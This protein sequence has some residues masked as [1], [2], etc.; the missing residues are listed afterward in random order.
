MQACLLLHSPF[1]PFSGSLM[2]S[3]KLLSANIL[4]LTS[5]HPLLGFLSSRSVYFPSPS[6]LPPRGSSALQ[7][8]LHSSSPLIKSLLSQSH[9]I[10]FAHF[11]F[12]LHLL[13]F[14][15]NFDIN[16]TCFIF[17]CIPGPFS[18]LA[19]ASSENCTFKSD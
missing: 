3:F 11:P 1:R 2:T 10:L 6:R 9:L 14:L 18:F 12:L 5:L 7:E 15:P 13:P 8:C 17:P 16:L 19:D 4:I